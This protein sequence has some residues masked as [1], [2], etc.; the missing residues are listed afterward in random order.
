MNGA[1]TVTAPKL[2]AIVVGVKAEKNVDLIPFHEND[3]CGVYKAKSSISPLFD[4]SQRLTC[5]GVVD[6]KDIYPTLCFKVR[7]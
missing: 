1:E 2:N 7:N 4:H 6:Q 5:H 3:V